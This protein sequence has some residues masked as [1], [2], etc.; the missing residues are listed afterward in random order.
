MFDWF[1][2]TTETLVLIAALVTAV[3]VI[4]QK[5]IR[6]LWQAGRRIH[7]DIQRVHALLDRELTH[8]GGSSLKDQVARI[9]YR[10]GG[11]EKNLAGLEGVVLEKHMEH[12]RIWAAITAI[13]SQTNPK[14]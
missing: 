14:D 12:E 10:Q 5:G 2:P 11:L 9:E 6:P 1:H 3:G 13:A 7:A 4:W 8:N